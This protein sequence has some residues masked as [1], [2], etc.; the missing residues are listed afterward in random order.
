MTH[1]INCD[2]CNPLMIQKVFCHETGCPNQKKKFDPE[3]GD[4]L[5]VRKC[6]DCGYEVAKEDPCCSA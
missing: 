6:F 3:T 2:Q 4:W 5:S 1:K